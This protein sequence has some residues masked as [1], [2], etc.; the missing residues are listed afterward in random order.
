MVVDVAL[1]WEENEAA[2]GQLPRSFPWGRSGSLG[3][4]TAAATTAV[5]L[6][7]SNWHPKGQQMMDADQ[8]KRGYAT[9]AT[10]VTQ[11]P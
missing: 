1:F 9:L 6:S 8:R 2:A 10:H 7:N 11:L 4:G 3:C 5:L